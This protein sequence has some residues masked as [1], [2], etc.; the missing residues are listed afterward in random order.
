MKTIAYTIGVWDLLH[1]GHIDALRMA[2]KFAD[3]LIVGVQHD[4]DVVR[5]KGK[6][7]V[8]GFSDRVKA[9]EALEFVDIVVGYNSNDYVSNLQNFDVDVLVLNDQYAIEPRFYEARKWILDN[10]KRI[11]YMPYNNTIS[12]T[13]LKKTWK[14]IWADVGGRA[15]LSDEQVGGPTMSMEAYGRMAAMLV[16]FADLNDGL[17]GTVVDFGCGS[18]LLMKALMDATE[19]IEVVGMEPSPSMA[20]RA[21]TNNPGCKVYVGDGLLTGGN[22]RLYIAAGVMH[23]LDSPEEAME[24]IEGMKWAARHVALIS[25]PNA[26]FYTER[27]T[28]RSLA[29]KNKWPKHVYFNTKDMEKSGF[30]IHPSTFFD[31][32]DCAFDAWW[33]TT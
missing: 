9:L 13:S 1:V 33:S 2:S 17:G 24:R 31:F 26:S 15:D 16:K 25:L 29:G 28:A 7:P 8:I 3:I 23:Y 10:K 27:E 4:E 11:A 18:G 5:Q 32:P 20:A 12:S 30:V 6:P 14:D 21:R 19:N 22:I